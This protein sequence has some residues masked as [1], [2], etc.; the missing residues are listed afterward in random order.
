MDE[1]ITGLPRSQQR[2][3]LILLAVIESG[4]YNE[5]KDILKKTEELSS[6]FEK[7]V[8]HNRTRNGC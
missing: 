7:K 4:G 6:S 1:A 3:F 8:S 2:K 5:T